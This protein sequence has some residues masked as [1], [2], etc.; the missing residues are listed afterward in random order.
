[1]TL[2]VALLGVLYNTD[3]S[4]LCNINWLLQLSSFKHFPQQFLVL[5]I[6]V[7]YGAKFVNG[8][9]YFLYTSRFIILEKKEVIYYIMNL[10]YT[11]RMP[12]SGMWRRID[13]V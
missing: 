11:L 7:T 9:I 13:L 1:M 4:L 6:P 5:C 2:P 10:I 8:Q 12:S 3:A